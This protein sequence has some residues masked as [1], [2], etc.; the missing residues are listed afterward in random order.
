MLEYFISIG[1][2]ALCTAIAIPLRLRFAESTFAMLYLLGVIVV[3]MRCRRR[4]AVLNALLSVTAFFYFCVPV[5]DSVVLEDYNYIITLMVMLIVALVI[6]TL[7]FKIRAQAADAIKAEIAIQ[8][9]RTRNALLSAVS[10]DIKT[11]IASIYGAA[12]SLLEGSARLEQAQRQDLIES[13]ATESERLNRV[14]SN[15]LEMTRLEAGFELR[16]DWYPLEELIGAALTRVETLLR[17]R[18]VTT[19]I[20][21]ELPLIFVEDVLIEEVLTNILENA[22][23]YTTAGTPI[24]ISAVESGTKITISV[25][26]QGPGFADG[27]EEHVFEKFFRSN[28][29]GIRGVGLGLAIC[30]T[31][32]QRHE[33][34]ITA[35]NR[36]GGGAVLTIEL[37]IGGTPPMLNA[38]SESS[39]T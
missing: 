28:S 21:P 23:K 39:L 5:H 1:V 36:P 27:E 22:G 4:A 31:I 33:G 6:S 34:R 14:V 13:I 9:E 7:T 26:D 17:G 10:H 18:T 32:V 35:G 30:R 25:R 37:P 16:R 3:S 29:N 15:L 38:L 11:P 24:E 8:T 12:T 2:V 20:P 19:T